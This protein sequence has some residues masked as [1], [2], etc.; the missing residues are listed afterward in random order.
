[1]TPAH[2]RGCRGGAESGGSIGEESRRGRWSVGEAGWRERRGA[3][4]WGEVLGER[5]E[6]GT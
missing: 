5:T 1:V 3:G 4:G 2:A 6:I